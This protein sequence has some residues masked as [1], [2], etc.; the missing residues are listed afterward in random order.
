[1]TAKNTVL[2]AM[3]ITVSTALPLE[4]LVLELLVLRLES[5]AEPEGTTS[6]IPHSKPTT[7][8]S[9][10]APPATR[11]NVL[12]VTCYFARSPQSDWRS[13]APGSWPGP[14]I[15]TSQSLPQQYPSPAAPLRV[16]VTV[17][18]RLA[19]NEFSGTAMR[20]SAMTDVPT[21]RK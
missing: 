15:G 13:P 3:K 5:L 17:G 8:P 18:Y 2:T 14:T 1:M 11:R 12:L 16:R 20:T 10:A 9:A 21:C 4:L 19:V 6:A 7:P